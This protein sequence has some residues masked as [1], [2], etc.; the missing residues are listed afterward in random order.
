MH[1]RTQLS[2]V[3]SGLWG[4]K[5][6]LGLP[7]KDWVPTDAAGAGGQRPGVRLAR[8]PV[9]PGEFPASL[10]L[11]EQAS[12]GGWDARMLVVWKRQSLY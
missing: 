6:E 4:A 5:G 1:T 8:R 10:G 12:L 9:T 2:G 7:R 11:D 3:P